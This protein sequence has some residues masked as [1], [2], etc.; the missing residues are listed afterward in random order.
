[1]AGNES[2]IIGED[3]TPKPAP[4]IAELGRDGPVEC[5]KEKQ[6]QRGKK[7]QPPQAGIGAPEGRQSQEGGVDSG[8][9]QPKAAQDVEPTT[10]GDGT[11]ISDKDETPKPATSMAQPKLAV[12]AGRN[13]LYNPP[14]LISKTGPTAKTAGEKA[15]TRWASRKKAGATRAI[16]HKAF[17][18]K[19]TA[20]LVAEEKRAADAGG[21][22]APAIT[23]THIKR[24]IKRETERVKPEDAQEKLEMA[25][26]MREQVAE[27]KKFGAE[28]Q[29]AAAAEKMAAIG[30]KVR[31]VE[32]RA[33]SQYTQVKTKSEKATA[34]DRIEK[35]S[36]E[37]EAA[38]MAV[39][40]G[41]QVDLSAIFGR[42]PG[43]RDNAQ[44]DARSAAHESGDDIAAELEL[45]MSCQE[46]GDDAKKEATKREG[47][48]SE[49]NRPAAKKAEE[50]A[51]I[52]ARATRYRKPE[53]T[54]DPPPRKQKRKLTSLPEPPD[55]ASPSV[56]SRPE[57]ARPQ[58]KLARRR[59]SGGGMT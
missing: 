20:E 29:Q 13:P 22:R 21:Y 27:N 51:N 19:I 50:K 48:A 12:G 18:D 57:P 45:E 34:Q 5:Q 28:K 25:A 15:A 53:S 2:V 39:A 46:A 3:E 31:V 58:R 54:K 4:N 52:L 23:Q 47:E 10:A 49:H 17:V 24:R 55:T 6:R 38:E 1:M 43:R 41:G 37:L 40:T 32:A 26:A 7:H 11:D 33:G 9:L 59:Q 14:P 36:A 44:L 30:V 35:L 56:K 8:G 16:N 42:K